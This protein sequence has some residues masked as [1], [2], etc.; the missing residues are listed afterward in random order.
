MSAYTGK[1]PDA[2]RK[3]PHRELSN[4]DYKAYCRI[5]WIRRQKGKKRHGK[6]DR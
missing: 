2:L 1:K 3:R 4:V 6:A 5:M